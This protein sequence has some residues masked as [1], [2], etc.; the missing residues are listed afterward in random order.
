MRLPYHRKLLSLFATATL[1]LTSFAQI[2]LAKEQQP[3]NVIF[4]LCDDL[5]WGDLGVFYQNDS[6]HN[7][8]HK[9][10]HLDQMAAEGMQMRR[11]YCPAPVC[12][13]SRSSLLTGV[14]QGNAVV[15][16]NQFDKMLEDN[17]TVASVMRT[18]G[19]RT[20][21]IGKYGLQGKGDSAETWLAYPTR[22]GF[23]EFYG[24][25]RHGDGHVHYPADTWDLGNSQ[26][27]RSKKEVWHNDKEVSEG[28]S[29]CYTTDLFTARS[30]DWIAKQT[31]ESPDEPFFLYLAYD[32]PHAALQ[33]PTVEYPSG[34]GLNGGVQWL[35]TP[36][37]MINTATGTID[38]Y[39]HPDYVRKGLSDVEERFATM[40]R[41]VDDCVGDLLQTLRDLEIDE[42]TLVVLSS[43]NGPHQ[44]A[45]I[46]KA[47]YNPDSFQSYGPFD[48]IK[49]DALEGG[50]RVPTLAWWPSHIKPGSIDQRPSQF[51]DW[52]PTLMELADAAAPART[53]GVS[54]VPRLLDQPDAPEGIVYVEYA[55]N[56]STPKY[57]DFAVEHRGSKRGQQ[58]VIYLDGYKGVRLNIQSHSDL[59]QIFDVTQ[60][61]DE[62]IDLAN[63]SP[64]FKTLQQRMQDRVLQIRMPNSSAKRPYDDALIPA[65]EPVETTQGISWTF[66]EGDFPY[67]PKTD[68]L[69]VNATGQ[70]DGLSTLPSHPKAGAVLVEGYFEIEEAGTYSVSLTSVSKAFLRVHDAAALDNDFNFELGETQTVEMNLARGLHPIRLTI[71]QD[72]EA[73]AGVELSCSK[74]GL[75]AKIVREE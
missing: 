71:L 72:A 62:V 60:D 35:G 42:N 4:I 15:R 69:T 33:V 8:T 21:L 61:L 30:K 75:T 28:L 11:H 66:F 64:E 7:K 40:V 68:L 2:S 73:A 23:D 16:D 47:D 44:E 3:P 43:D 25:V 54:L 32:T 38:S 52:L 18:A 59:F 24:Y 10:P 58:Q 6:T 70:A 46:Q 22:R 12:A 27:H 1:L 67:V 48:G 41:R 26:G 31:Q 63:S 56:G 50:I 55:Q 19:Y 29:K 13:P 5:G 57:E 45:Y 65:V 39:R 36:G 20:A 17:H 34:G 53:D 9:T 14:H 74:A 51:H 49:R 37:N